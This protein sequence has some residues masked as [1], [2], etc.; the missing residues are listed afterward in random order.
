MFKH[1]EYIHVQTCGIYTCLIL[2][3][4]ICCVKYIYILS[5]SNELLLLKCNKLIGSHLDPHK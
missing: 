1:V 4:V 2:E 5:D 3:I